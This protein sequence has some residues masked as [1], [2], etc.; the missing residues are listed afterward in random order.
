MATRNRLHTFTTAWIYAVTTDMAQTAPPL[1]PIKALL[2]LSC[3]S[4]AL[5]LFWQANTQALGANPVE[6]VQRWTGIWTLNLLLITL[7]ISPLRSIT[8]QHWLL[9]LR[10]MLGLFTFFYAVLHFL[11][12]IGFDHDFAVDAIARDILRR[13]FVTLG[14]AA[15]VLLIPLAATSNAWAI[16]RLGGKRWQELHRSVYLIAILGCLH[17]LWL[18]KITQLVE[19]LIYSV[20]LG[21]LLWWRIQERR[22]KATPAPSVAGAKKQAA[23][24]LKFYPKRPG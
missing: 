24:P 17:F 22:R 13:P 5:W 16:R 1:A 20:A 21:I 11:S 18:S 9:R 6:T 7:C 4:P 23:Q 10:R 8:Q 12:F 14:F 15:F 3:L 2:F 19:P